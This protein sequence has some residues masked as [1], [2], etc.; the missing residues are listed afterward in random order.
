MKLRWMKKMIVPIMAM[1]FVY[2]A[3]HFGATMEPINQVTT[4]NGLTELVASEVNAESHH[5]VYGMHDS[6][7]L[8]R[9]AVEIN[10]QVSWVH[11]VFDA[12]T[13]DQSRL[14]DRVSS[15]IPES[16]QLINYEIVGTDITLNLSR[17]F[18]D[19]EAR[20]ERQLLSSLVWSLTEGSEIDRVFF[21]IEGEPVSNLN[22][23]LNVG[24]GLTRAMGINIELETQSANT[25][26]VMLF[27]LTGD[28]QNQYLVPVTRVV[29]AS[30]DPVAYAVNALSEGPRGQ[31]YLSFVSPMANLI[32]APLVADGVLTLNFD[33]GLFF[34]QHQ[35]MVSSTAI[36][37]LVMTLTEQEDIESVSVLVEGSARVFDDQTRPIAVPATRTFVDP[38]VS[39][40]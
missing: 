14:S 23:A 13:I 29:D 9:T 33:G 2:Y 12:L 22:S 7:Y 31:S 1:L 34:D 15:L 17:E 35:T 11:S 18:L 16:A 39:A 38:F 20:W 37:Q 8:V 25:Q 5:V 27:F 19:Y 36:M 10:P 40:Q 24:N 32:E 3:Q 6:N 28:N 26:Q 4:I 30:M 21:R